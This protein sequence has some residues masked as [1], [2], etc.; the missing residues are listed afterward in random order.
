[1]I[2]YLNGSVLYKDQDFLILKASSS[3]GYK[4]FVSTRLTTECNIGQNLEL[5]VYTQYKENDVSLFGFASMQ[6]QKCFETLIG[7]QGVGAKMAQATLSTLT[8]E[9][10]FYAIAAGEKQ[11]FTKVS[12]IGPK[13]ASRIVNE[14]AGK[15][16]LPASLPAEIVSSSNKGN[17]NSAQQGTASPNPI[18]ADVVSALANMG[19][20]RS[21]AFQIASKYY[22]DNPAAKFEDIFKQTL[23]ELSTVA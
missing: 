15:I 5:F 8:T 23:S 10:I 21:Q 9:E 7:V 18:V 12:G 11:A 4:V 14:L 17:K 3:V 16:E 13:L 22:L 19:F 2:A 1:M 20:V 6:E